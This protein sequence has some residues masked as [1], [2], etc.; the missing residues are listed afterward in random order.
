M[1]SPLQIY[2]ATAHLR[3]IHSRELKVHMWSNIDTSS[4][5]VRKSFSAL[6]VEL[7]ASP[8]QQNP[9][10]FA[11]VVLICNH[12]FVSPSGMPHGACLVAGTFRTVLV[13]RWRVPNQTLMQQLEC[14]S[15]CSRC[16]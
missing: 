10:P 11:T 13:M 9:V 1:L 15:I 3:D 8:A 5:C 2:L 4:M 6:V 7:C 12:E 16:A 14:T